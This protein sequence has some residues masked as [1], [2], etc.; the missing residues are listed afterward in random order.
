MTE[1]APA[2]PDTP[3]PDG[4]P[5]E[6]APAKERRP[7]GWLAASVKAVCDRYITG[8]LTLPEGKSLT[9]HLVAREVQKD[10]GMDKPPSVGAVS[11][12]FKR[13]DEYEFAQFSQKPFAFTDYTEKGREKGLQGIIADRRTVRKE[14]RASRKAEDKPETEPQVGGDIVG[15]DSGPGSDSH[16]NDPFSTGF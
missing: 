16:V 14:E 13:W 6:D 11:A 7:R 8:A 9:P 5:E 10:E 2:T 15:G 4:V 1:E 12:V 3:E